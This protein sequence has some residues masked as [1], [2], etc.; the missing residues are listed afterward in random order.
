[1]WCFYVSYGT[2]YCMARVYL[3]RNFMGCT[4]GVFMSIA[5]EDLEETRRNLTRY[6]GEFRNCVKA[7]CNRKHLRTYVAGQ[8]SDLPRKSV[9]PI[10]RAADVP[11]RTL[12]EFLG[13]HQWDHAAVRRRV[14]RLVMR[15]HADPNAMAVIDETSFIKK[16]NKTAGVQRQY[17]GASGKTDNCVVTVHVGYAAGDFH[18]LL[19]GDLFL[20]KA[21]W[22]GDRERCRAAGI[23]DEVV[24][25]PKWQIALDLLDRTMANGV[26]FKYLSADEGYGRYASFRVGVD[27]RRLIYVVEVDR[28]QCGWTPHALAR[29]GNARRVDRLW[30]RGGPSWTLFHIKNT[31]N[32]PVVWEVRATRFVPREDKQP[33]QEC[34]LLVA[35]NVLDGEVKYFL[36]NAPAEESLEVLLHVAFN[37]WHIERVFEDAKGEIGLD[38]FEVRHYLPIMRHLVLSMVSFLF[39]M[40]ETQRLQKKPFMDHLPSTRGRRSAT[41]PLHAPTRTPAPAPKGCTKNRTR[42]TRRRKS[43]AIPHQNTIPR[44]QNHGHIC[45]KNPKVLPCIL[46]L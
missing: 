21:S 27:S 33:G 17:C 31:G 40:Q 4:E 45:L 10:A 36:S 20:P 13:L 28:S 12:Q 6:L 18:A 1:M 3:V 42:P 23:S 19:D 38:H 37:R 24:Y 39:L 16:G 7:A 2:I 15:D 44:T 9:E 32:G 30:K 22:N 26:R 34:W 35:R 11:P 43:R 8:V 41:R 46:A 14:Q 29:R 25:R 5:I